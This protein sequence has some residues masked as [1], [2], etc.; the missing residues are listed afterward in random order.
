[1]SKKEKFIEMV[2]ELINNIEPTNLDKDALEYFEKFKVIKET[3]KP[4]FT[5]NG[6]K[7]LQFMQEN[8]DKYN[9]MFKA[10]EIGEGLFISSR[11]AGGALRKLVTDGYAEKIGE[12]PVVYTLTDLGMKVD[13][14]E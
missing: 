9:N 10:K 11:G 5:E 2:E 6:K 4:K 13:L 12:N 14:T 8:K 1:M 7:V 3:E